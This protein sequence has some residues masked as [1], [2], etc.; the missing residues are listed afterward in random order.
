MRVSHVI[1][2][3]REFTKSPLKAM[4]YLLDILSPSSQ[5]T[6]NHT[7]RSNFLDSLFIG[8]EDT[9]MILNICSLDRMVADINKFQPFKAPGPDGLYP[10]LLQK[11]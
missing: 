4:N 1:K 5:Q 11:C 7:T 9:E 10:V 6:G 8:P 2:Q 3:N